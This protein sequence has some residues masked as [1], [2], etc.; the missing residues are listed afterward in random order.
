MTYMQP[1]L[2]AKKNLFIPWSKGLTI[3]LLMY[4]IEIRKINTCL[5]EIEIF[6]NPYNFYII[7]QFLFALY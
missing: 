1:T 2:N 7:P 5:I 3:K 4:F 6:K